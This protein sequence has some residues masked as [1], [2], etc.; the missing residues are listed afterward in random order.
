[1]RSGKQPARAGSRPSKALI[2]V[3]AGV[4]V[5]MFGVTMADALSPTDRSVLTS[6]YETADG[7]LRVVRPGDRCLSS[8]VKVAWPNRG[9]TGQAGPPGDDGLPGIPG[10]PGIRGLQGLR[11]EKG[12][13]GSR[14]VRGIQGIQGL[15]GLQGEPGTPGAPGELGAQ[16]LAGETGPAGPAGPEGP[17]GPAGPEGRQGQDGPAGARGPAGPEGPQGPAG[18]VGPA[19][20]PG[21]R[22]PEGPVGPQGPAGEQGPPGVT[23][24]RVLTSGPSSYDGSAQQSVSCPEG[25]VA[26][27]GGGSTEGDQVIEQSWPMLSGGEPTGWHLKWSAN[28]PGRVIYVIC[29]G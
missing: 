26:T 4:G 6:C 12:E 2:G 8:E 10:I 24:F 27:G 25:T 7:S 18:D 23:A 16:G 28:G 20:A 1:M 3:A 22:G 5:A 17:A 11:G 13:P 21:A 29:A 14:G 19:G 9:K 15:Q